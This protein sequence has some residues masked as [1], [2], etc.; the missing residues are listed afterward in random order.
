MEDEQEKL[1]RSIHRQS[2]AQTVLQA[3]AVAELEAQRRQLAAQT[4]FLKDEAAEAKQER[5]A[6]ARWMDAIASTELAVKAGNPREALLTCLRNKQWL[7]DI[8]ESVGLLERVR[9]KELWQIKDELIKR[10]RLEK[11]QYFAELDGWLART[12]IDSGIKEVARLTEELMALVDEIAKYDREAMQRDAAGS[13][14]L[15][16]NGALAQLLTKARSTLRTIALRAD[17]IEKKLG[18]LDE[19]RRLIVAEYRPE[20]G[21]FLTENSPDIRAARNEELDVIVNLRDQARVKAKARR[22]GW[23]ILFALAVIVTVLLAI[24]GS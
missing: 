5:F 13:E 11:P 10:M 20:I 1:L 6:F 22:Y 18:K 21:S 15:F 12:N 17:P 3:G 2:V 8:P 14:E 23:L 4:Q 16:R 7:T 9:A 19:L 24:F